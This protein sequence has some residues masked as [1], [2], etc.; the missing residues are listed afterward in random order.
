MVSEGLVQLVRDKNAINLHIIESGF[1]RR[2]SSVWQNAT[3]GSSRSRWNEA[4]TMIICTIEY[5]VRTM[6]RYLAPGLELKQQRII[7]DISC[8]TK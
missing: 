8:E 7:V 4:K 5:I 3:E 1:D 2:F 6:F